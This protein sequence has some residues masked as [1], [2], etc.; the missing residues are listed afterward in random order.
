MQ[1][2]LLNGFEEQKWEVI[3]IRKSRIG[4]EELVVYAHTRPLNW[5]GPEKSEKLPWE[6]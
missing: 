4:K 5:G 2:D 3:E 6:N 1:G